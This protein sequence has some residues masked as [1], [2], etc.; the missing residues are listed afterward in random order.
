MVSAA[1]NVC[2]RPAVVLLSRAFPGQCLMFCAVSGKVLIKASG[3]TTVTDIGT[4]CPGRQGGVKN[5]DTENLRPFGNRD[6]LD[7]ITGNDGIIGG[8]K[9]AASAQN[10]TG[11]RVIGGYTGEYCI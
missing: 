10:D 2:N 11:K 5:V 8:G 4:G 6:H 9:L 7:R 3:V 1:V